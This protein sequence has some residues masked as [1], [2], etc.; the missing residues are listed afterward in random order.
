MIAQR[1]LATSQKTAVLAILGHPIAGFTLTTDNIGQFLLKF[2]TGKFVTEN[3]ILFID[4]LSDKI[5]GFI[6]IADQLP[7]LLGSG[8]GH[9][10]QAPF[11]SMS[12]SF[13]FGQQEIH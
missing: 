1:V 2:I 8:H 5:R 11:F 7:S 9:I 3:V 10:K 13:R 12:K 4:Q 6:G